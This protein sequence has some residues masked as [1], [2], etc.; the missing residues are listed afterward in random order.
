[1]SETIMK[2]SSK[3]YKEL[4]ESLGSLFEMQNEDNDRKA[5]ALYRAMFVNDKDINKLDFNYA[6]HIL[7]YAEFGCQNAVID[8]KNYLNYLR[9]IVPEEYPSHLRMFEES[10]ERRN[11]EDEV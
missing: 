11:E 6:D 2:N 1:M 9:T 10:M 5:A 7:G 3:D 4:V 8:Y